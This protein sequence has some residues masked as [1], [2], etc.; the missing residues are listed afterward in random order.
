MKVI[1]RGPA[2]PP[3]VPPGMYYCRACQSVFEMD[4]S[5]ERN[6]SEVQTTE[7]DGISFKIY[8]PVERNPRRMY[9]WEKTQDYRDWKQSTEVTE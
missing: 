8:C 1:R 6:I 2:N 4:E 9:E 3:R 7:T 5:D